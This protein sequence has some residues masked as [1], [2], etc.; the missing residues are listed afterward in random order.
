MRLRSSKNRPSPKARAPPP[1]S[2]K[3][4]PTKKS[5]NVRKSTVGT[6]E[7]ILIYLMAIVSLVHPINACRKDLC[8]E[9]IIYR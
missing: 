7:I 9:D 8:L 6:I 1:K 5:K 4:Q 2:N 3:K